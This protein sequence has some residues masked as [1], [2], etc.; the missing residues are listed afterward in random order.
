MDNATWAID[1]DGG[2]VRHG[3]P[4][5]DYHAVP[6]YSASGGTLLRRSAAHYRV[7]RTAPSEPTE[8]MVFG[9]AMHLAALEPDEFSARVVRAQRFDRRTTAGKA[10]AAAF[11]AANAGKIVLAPDQFDAIG[12]MRESLRAHPAASA[13]LREGDAEVSLFWRCSETGARCKARPDFLPA[14]A[15]ICV[16][17]KTTQDASPSGFARSAAALGYHVAA[18]HYLDGCSVLG[19]EREAFTLIAVEK[20][21]PFAIAA[22]R[23]PDDALAVGRRLTMQARRL[24]AQC[25]HADSWPAYSGQIVDL[26]LPS[27]AHYDGEDQ[28]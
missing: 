3:M 17:L 14:G 12:A 22:Y 16:D 8:A 21:P 6:A 9:T 10:N 26:Q 2:E 4:A 15:R 7:S 11:D 18:W 27:W 1:F 19:L 23:V 28:T 20:T 13:L 24:Y 25:V 5:E